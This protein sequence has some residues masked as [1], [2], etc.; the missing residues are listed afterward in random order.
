MA[1]KQTLTIADSQNRLLVDDSQGK[2]VNGAYSYAMLI[3]CGELQTETFFRLLEDGSYRLLEDDT[4]RRLLE[5][6]P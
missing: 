4:S 2:L 1:C 3:E 6:A 5:A